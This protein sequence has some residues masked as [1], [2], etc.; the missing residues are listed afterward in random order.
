VT[1]A[2]PPITIRWRGHEVRLRHDD[3]QLREHTP[4][5]AILRSAM[6]LVSSVDGLRLILPMALGLWY[7]I[8][9]ADD[10][11]WVGLRRKA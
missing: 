2:T 11:S 4:N 1:Y 10:A 3:P 8:K 9:V 5:V 7:Q 6:E